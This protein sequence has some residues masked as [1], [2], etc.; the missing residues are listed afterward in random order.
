[1]SLRVPAQ[2][3]P[4]FFFDPKSNFLFLFLGSC[5]AIVVGAY[6]FIRGFR[7]LYRKRLIETTPT[8][9]IRAAAMGPVEIHGKATG[10][11]SLISPV[12]V[13][14]CYFY[15]SVAWVAGGRE[16][17]REHWTEV[18]RE[19]VCVPFFVCDDTGSMMIDARGAELGM[20]AEF[21]GQLDSYGTSESVRHFL[22]RHGVTGAGVVRVRERVVKPDDT[23]YVLGTLAEHRGASSYSTDWSPSEKETRMLSQQGADLQRR[24][25]LSMMNVDVTPATVLPSLASGQKFDLEPAASVQKGSGGRPF[26]I[27]TQS[28]RELLVEMARD[29]IRYVWGGP[30]LLLVGLAILLWIIAPH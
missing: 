12:S 8:S 6:Y 10:P 7:I 11:Y 1:M 18:A 16:Q 5:A 15:E 29:S 9:K 24:M 26:V 13:V 4:D 30:A 14:D 27:A 20:P 17:E 19:S 2:Q 28:E 3:R 23:L 21:E 25:A 22:G